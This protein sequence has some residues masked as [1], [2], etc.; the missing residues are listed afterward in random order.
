MHANVCKHACTHTHAHTHRL[1]GLKLQWE[2]V[3]FSI[4]LVYG[5]CSWHLSTLQLLIKESDC[6]V[7][8]PK[9]G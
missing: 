3:M 9:F 1:C 5:W 4:N 8:W 6:F 2:D 7:H